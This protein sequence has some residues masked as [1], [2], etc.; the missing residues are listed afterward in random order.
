MKF[1]NFSCISRLRFLFKVEAIVLRIYCWSRGC[2]YKHLLARVCSFDKE[3]NC[4]LA[5]YQTH[6]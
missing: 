2:F 5:A 4:L 1:G 6:E 3:C